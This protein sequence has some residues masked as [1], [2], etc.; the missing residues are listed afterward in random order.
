MKVGDAKFHALQSFVAKANTLIKC[1]P[2]T[3]EPT[4]CDIWNRLATHNECHKNKSD[5]DAHSTKSDKHN[6]I[7]VITLFVSFLPSEAILSHFLSEVLCSSS[8]ISLISIGCAA[9]V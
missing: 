4:I 5:I 3:R 8:P 6:P 2:R 7:A 1:A 9:A